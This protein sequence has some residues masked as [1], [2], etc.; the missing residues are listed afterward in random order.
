MK[1][2]YCNLSIV[3]RFVFLLFLST[4]FAK[5]QN[6]TNYSDTLLSKNIEPITGALKKLGS[7]KGVYYNYRADEFKSLQL[8]TLRHIGIMAQGIEKV[9]P[10]LANTN[11]N[12]YKSVYYEEM[13]PLLL[14][15]IKELTMQNKGLTAQYI[16]LLNSLTEKGVIDK[17]FLKKTAEK[18]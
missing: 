3:I 13:V 9:M 8:D 11:A 7:A 1:S 4:T 18:K 2:S 10:E 12:G 6:T 17:D 16:H 15:A 14:E 5:A